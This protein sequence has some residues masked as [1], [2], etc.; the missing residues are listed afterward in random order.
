MKKLLKAEGIAI[1]EIVTESR[2][3]MYLKNKALDW[4]APIIFISAALYS[5]N[6]SLVSVAL[7]VV[8]NY[9][10]DFLKG[11]GGSNQVRLEIV[12]EN[13]SGGSFKRILYKGPAKGVGDL[14]HIVE[15]SLHD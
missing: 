9:A 11:L 14:A 3:P 13:T 6:P 1:E 8:G 5:Q 7:G 10:T 2:R 12:V 4:A 15:R